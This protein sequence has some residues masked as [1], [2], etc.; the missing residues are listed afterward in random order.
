M[1]I[2][3]IDFNF[4]HFSNNPF[5]LLILAV[6]HL[7]ISGNDSNNLHPKNNLLIFITLLVFQFDISSMFI[8]DE[9]PKNKQFIFFKYFVFKFEILIKEDKVSHSLNIES[10][11]TTLSNSLNFILNKELFPFLIF[12]DKYFLLFF[13][14]K[15]AFFLFNNKNF[16]STIFVSSFFS[17]IL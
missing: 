5:I 7:E 12:S 17:L 4:V 3:G 8:N 13:N 15:K 2:S 16:L 6:F 11:L 1:E 9:Q 14:I 10:I